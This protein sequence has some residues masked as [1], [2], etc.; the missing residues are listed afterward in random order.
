[1]ENCCG[2]IIKY[3]LFILN[4]LVALSGLALIGLGAYVQIEDKTFYEFLSNGYINTPIFLIIIGVVIFVIAFFGC[5]GAVCENKCMISTYALVI[6][7]ILIAEIG[8]GV[9]AYL[10]RADLRDA[11]KNTMTNYGK[12]DHEEITSTWDHVQ[13]KLRCCGVQNSTDWGMEIPDSCCSGGDVLN[14]AKDTP[15][16]IFNIG[17]ADQVEELVSDNIHFVGVGACLIGLLH[18]LI[19]VLACCIGKHMNNSENWDGK[20]QFQRV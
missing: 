2:S 12:V 8:A 19:I 7:F 17:C 1:M 10:L 3:I 5:C 15:K 14:C 18:I 11:M 9:A 4:L 13:Q 20:G 6:F 16:M